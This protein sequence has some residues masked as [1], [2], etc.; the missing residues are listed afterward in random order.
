V[1]ASVTRFLDPDA[2]LAAAAD[3]L[4]FAESRPLGGTWV[5]DALL[6]RLRIGKEMRRLVRAGG[7]R[8]LSGCCS[9]WWGPGSPTSSTSK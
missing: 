7:T 6:S 1:V 4:G 8:P 2:V 5:L 3:G 9:R